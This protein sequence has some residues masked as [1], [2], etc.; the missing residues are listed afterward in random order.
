MAKM[1][2]ITPITI[3][4]VFMN[5]STQRS[6]TM[7]LFHL[8]IQALYYLAAKRVNMVRQKPQISRTFYIF[9]LICLK[10][11][12]KKAKKGFT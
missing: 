11:M 9:A 6:K 10:Q 4:A 3:F 8:I 2:V 7:S 5:A 12:L 1:I